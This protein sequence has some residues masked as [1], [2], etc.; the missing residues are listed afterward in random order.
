MGTAASVYAYA[1]E[2]YPARLFVPLA[3]FLGV[4]ALASGSARPAA[5]LP[6]SLAVSSALA[7]VL[8]FQFRLWDD[9]EDREH[10][11]TTHPE[12]VM[13]R[14]A[15][16]KPFRLLLVVVTVMNLALVA[17]RGGV[18]LAALVALEVAL[19]AWYRARGSRT[20]AAFLPH[21]IVLAKYP[22]LVFVV[23]PVDASP[24]AEEFALVAAIVYLCCCL[25]EVL[26]DRE[27]RAASQA[28]RL[29][30]VESLFLI[31]TA[32]ALG[33][34][35]GV[36]GGHPLAMRAAVVGAFVVVLLVSVFGRGAPPVAVFAA[37]LLS[38]ATRAITVAR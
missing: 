20:P 28:K 12:R 27:L 17:A 1:R 37:G 8:I 9:L 3:V 25:H 5:G 31:A 29:L 19:L 22:V 7:F 10:D 2:R 21:H 33:L 34:P 24:H 14:A 18:R 30:V 15:T 36:A 11:R 16:P 6:A 26:H 38:L 32:A 23:S 35:M 4:A 13:S